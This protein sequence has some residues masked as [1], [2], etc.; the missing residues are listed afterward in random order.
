MHRLA[1][2]R[3]S[4]TLV[5]STK[6]DRPLVVVQIGKRNRRVAE[7]DRDDAGLLDFPE[8]ARELFGIRLRGTKSCGERKSHH[9]QA[10]HSYSPRPDNCGNACTVQSGNKT[11]PLSRLTTRYYARTGPLLEPTDLH[12]LVGIRIRGN[13]EGLANSCFS[14]ALIGTLRLQPLGRKPSA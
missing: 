6:T 10:F 3:G 9:T 7:A 2:A 8:R 5:K 13:S 1:H 11:Q 4:V 12:R 14:S